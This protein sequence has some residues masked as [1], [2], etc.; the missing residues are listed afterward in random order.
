MALN[1]MKW[2]ART[3]AYSGLGLFGFY[4]LFV[5]KWTHHFLYE[6]TVKNSKPEHVWEFVADFSN[7]IKL[8]PTLEEFNIIAES[9]NYEHWKY[10]VQYTEHLSHLPV[11]K[12]TAHGHFSVK[13]RTE[14]YVIESNHR[15]CFFLGISCLESNSEFIFEPKG[16]DTKCIEKIDYECPL[17]FSSICRREVMYQR[18]EI[19]KNLQT[20]F[21]K[22]NK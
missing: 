20:Y 8:N 13:P 12:N 7:M 5:Y 1:P 15:T 18:Q 2:K 6:A 22:R 21:D 11:I 9:G 10:S 17:V 19:M 3:L 16:Q 4:F 14:G